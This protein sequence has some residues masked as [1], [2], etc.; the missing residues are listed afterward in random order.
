MVKYCII[1]SNEIIR[2][3]GNTKRG[4]GHEIMMKYCSKNKYELYKVDLQKFI[5]LIEIMVH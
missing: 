2:K 3:Y 4:K 5:L 1:T